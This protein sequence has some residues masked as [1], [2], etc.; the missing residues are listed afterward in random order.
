MWKRIG[1]IWA[2]LRSDLKLLWAAIRHP[3]CPGF[4]KL[5]ALGVLLYLFFP[6]DF[7]PDVLPIIGAV[8]DV[9]VVTLGVKWLVSKLPAALRAELKA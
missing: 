8:D 5:G 4:I 3:A 2:A 9:M 6:I 7:I 1:L